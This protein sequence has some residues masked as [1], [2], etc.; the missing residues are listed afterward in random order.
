MD[1]WVVTVLGDGNVGKTALA[2]RFI[3]NEFT[4]EATIED[5]YRKEI[6]VDN[7]AC[8]L[9]V[10]DTAGHD[11]HQSLH[12]QWV[13]TGQGFAIVFSITSQAS[14]A[15]VKT[16]YESV[17]RSKQESITMVLVG[18]KADLESDREVSLMEG[19]RLAQAFGCNY[20][21]TSAKTSV[22]VQR[23]FEELVR[24]LRS[25][26]NRRPKKCVIM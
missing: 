6:A 3:R 2:I 20:I 1:K 8:L 13:Q 22:D 5:A 24:S 11:E 9:E 15:R 16:L 12:D 18:N 17:R 26:Y 4:Y 7:R 14:F 10:I 23:V 21:E 19:Q 25:R